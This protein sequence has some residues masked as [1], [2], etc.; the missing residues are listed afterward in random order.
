MELWMETNLQIRCG[1]ILSSLNCWWRTG[2]PLLFYLLH[3]YMENRLTG[4]V[5]HSF[6]FLCGSSNTQRRKMHLLDWR[7]W[8]WNFVGRVG[9]LFFLFAYI[10]PWNRSH[11]YGFPGGLYRLSKDHL[12]KASLIKYACKTC[13]CCHKQVI[14]HA[15]ICC[16]RLWK[17]SCH[18]CK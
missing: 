12:S 1:L 4:C 15:K 6:H 17:T 8:S 3:A 11:L 14:S 16:C 7:V 18:S 10:Y 2:Q 13:L 9:P 5:H